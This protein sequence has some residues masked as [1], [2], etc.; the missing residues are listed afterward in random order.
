M[1]T[2]AVIGAEALIRWQH[3][4]RGLLAPGAF[5]PFIDRHPLMVEL[6][7]WVIETA[8]AQISTWRAMGKVLPVSVNVDALQLAQAD[9]IAKLGQAL[10]RYPQVQSS[11]LEL[12]ILE[13]SALE[14]IAEVSDTLHAG[15]A[16]GVSFALDDF[17]T[18]Y[19]S[20][21]YLKRLPVAIIKIDQS[22]VRDM[23]DDPN[24]LAILEG[25]IS[26]AGA[27]Q[28]KVI[29]EGVET[30]AH[31]ERLLQLGCTLGQGYAIARPMPAEHIL[32]WWARHQAKRALH[33]AQIAVKLC[34]YP[35]THEQ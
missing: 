34:E 23:L 17:G 4:G 31:S 9:F 18:G 27:F 14:D 1:R 25:I 32:S 11:D 24:D 33:R 35:P 16:L 30:A 26:L 13:T 12:E 28:R 29:A 15:R 21:S 3:P 6:G 7:D 19:S 20:L 8:L 5:L 2:G 22:F 10:A